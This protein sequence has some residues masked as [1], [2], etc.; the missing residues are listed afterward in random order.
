MGEKGEKGREREQ[1]R[2]RLRFLH[3]KIL[4]KHFEL[5]GF[6]GALWERQRTMIEHT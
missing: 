6:C 2:L 4:R 5:M 1:E 3:F